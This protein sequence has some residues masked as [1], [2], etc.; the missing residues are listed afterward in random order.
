MQ[1]IAQVYL[2]MH[3]QYKQ[4]L[5]PV[6]HNMTIYLV[7]ISIATN[8]SSLIIKVCR[9][10]YMEFSSYFDRNEN[11]ARLLHSRLLVLARVYTCRVASFP[12]HSQILSRSRSCGEKIGSGLGMRLP[13]EYVLATRI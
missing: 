8:V 12:G 7:A 2:W 6:S 4:S 13:V 3:L 5:S 10:T 9:D 1:L 11:S